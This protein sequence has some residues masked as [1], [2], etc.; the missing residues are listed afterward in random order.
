MNSVAD[1]LFI[2]DIV[3]RLKKANFVAVICDGPT[4]V[5]VT[6]QEVVHVSYRTS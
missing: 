3:E 5:S 1:Y 6:E 2:K 4:D